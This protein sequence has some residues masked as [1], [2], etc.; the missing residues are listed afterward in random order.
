M[1]TGSSADRS[2]NVQ[3]KRGVNAQRVAVRSTAWLGGCGDIRGSLELA[4]NVQSRGKI[5]E[6]WQAQHPNGE[7]KFP[8]SIAPRDRIEQGPTK[9]L[10][11]R[12]GVN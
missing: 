11:C 1:A 8:A 4:A 9:G 3:A 5:S 7:I 12:V 2:E 10:M 6:R